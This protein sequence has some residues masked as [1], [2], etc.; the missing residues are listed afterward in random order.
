MYRSKIFDPATAAFSAFT[1]HPPIYNQLITTFTEMEVAYLRHAVVAGNGFSTNI[2]SLRDEINCPNHD[3]NKIYKMG[4]IN[5]KNDKPYLHTANLSSSK[6]VH[7]IFALIT[8]LLINGM[9][10]L[11]YYGVR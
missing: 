1:P 5:N 11:N 7:T 2:T 10:L 8:L 9:R 3:F 4:R 6:N